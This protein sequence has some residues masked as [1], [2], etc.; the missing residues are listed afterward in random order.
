MMPD[1][2][3]D[4]FA[5]LGFAAV[6]KWILLARVVVLA[7]LLARLMYARMSD[8]AIADVLAD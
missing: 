4:R 1:P 7:R 6:S 8:L 2:S 5:G 3:M